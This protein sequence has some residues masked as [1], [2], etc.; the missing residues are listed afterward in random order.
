MKRPL[1]ILLC[2][3]AFPAAAS[4]L[5]DW[6]DQLDEALTVPAFHNQVR[7][8]LSGLVDLEGYW[9]RQPAPGLLYTD[10]NH[11]FNPRL[12]LFF[13]AQVGKW[14]YFFAQAR[15][16]H[17]FDPGDGSAQVR[18][19]EYALRL[20]PWDQGRLNLQVGKF[21]T[22]VG[23]WQARHLSWD[24]PFVTAPL[25][26][27]N[28]TA[29]Y[30][31]EASGSARGFLYRT[32]VPNYEFNPVIWGPAY[33]TGAAVSGRLGKFDYAAEL[34]NTSLS[35]RPESWDATQTGFAHPTWSGR[36]GFRPNPMWNLG[37]SASVGPY[38][39]PEAI[40]TLPPGRGLGD[41]R[42]MVLGQDL[43][44]AW[45]HVQ[46]RAEFYESRFEVPYVGNADIYAYYFEAQYKFTPRL[47]GALR[48]NQ[49]LFA[50]IRN[51][52]GGLTPWGRDL[53]RIDTS[54]GY[55]F[56]AHTQLK[57]QY[58]LQ[59]EDADARGM[60]HLLATQFTLRF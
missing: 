1:V 2:L 19:D 18:L 37:V 28:V 60:A 40:S 46:L 42:E 30:D 45:H 29:I 15:A 31:T 8:R 43:S 5:D 22:V 4:G 36:A 27:E 51:G 41:Y 34:K 26:Y 3:A 17:G 52:S 50:N 47:V 57:L 35:A 16:D 54:F 11:L 9:F 25:P 49:R 32:R 24:N 55:R 39:R 44:F 38:F 6:L 56:T 58:S 12:T 48:W 23:S 14:L 21:A 10:G 7:T 33:G 59:R 20:M 13:D 53:W